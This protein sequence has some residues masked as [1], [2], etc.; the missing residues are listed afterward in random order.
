MALCAV[1]QLVQAWCVKDSL[2]WGELPAQEWE[3]F[4]QELPGLLHSLSIWP[5]V[6]KAIVGEVFED[7]KP[8]A[9]GDIP[10]SLFLDFS[11][12]PRFDECPSVAKKK[13]ALLFPWL[14]LLKMPPNL[15]DLFGVL[16]ALTC[17][18][19]LLSFFFFSISTGSCCKFPDAN[20]FYQFL[21]SSF[22]KR[23]ILM[24]WVCLGI[25]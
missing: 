24:F 1:V 23:K 19:M 14:M 4:Q 18:L 11:E 21:K 5:P 3:P 10:V 16:P 2:S 17:Q 15:R 13:C 7:I 12:K 22:T 20:W 8:L 6:L 9:G 25:F